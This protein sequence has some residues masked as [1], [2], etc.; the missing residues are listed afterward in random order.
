[1]GHGDLASQQA[2]RR[3]NR[4]D[5]WERAQNGDATALPALRAL[6]DAEPDAVEVVDMARQVELSLIKAAA[7]PQNLLIREALPRKLAAMRA[8][9]GGQGPTPL[10]RLLVERV[11]LCW[12]QLHYFEA[13]YTQNMGSLTLAQ[14]HYHQRRIDRAHRRYLSAIKALA[15]VRRLLRPVVAQINIADRQVNVSAAA[16]G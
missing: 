9:L 3:G 16:E 11:V 7:G 4:E 14:G 1:M 12:L 13:A 8:E 2:E 10:E 6:F 5:L 15:T